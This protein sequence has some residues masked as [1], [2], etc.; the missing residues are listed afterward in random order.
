MQILATIGSGVFGGAGVD[1]RSQWKSGK[2]A[3]ICMGD[4]VWDTYPYAKFHNDPITP[5]VPQ[6]CENS[7]EVTPLVFWVLPTTYRQDPCT[8]FYDQYVK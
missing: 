3:K 7:H 1:S 8:D 5:F 6:M 2:F 4:Y